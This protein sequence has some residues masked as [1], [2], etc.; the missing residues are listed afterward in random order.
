M[1]LHDKVA[2][3]TGASRGLGRQIALEFGRRGAKVVIAAR[4]VAPRRTLEGTIFQT[5]DMIKAE[6]GHAIAIGCDVGNPDDIRNLVE[7][8]IGEFGRL[9]IVVNNAADMTGHELEPMVEA[10][11]GR[12]DPGTE[13]AAS[14]AKPS[15]R[16]DESALQSWL[17]QFAV[18][19]H[20]PF[21]LTNLARPYMRA[22]GG[23]VIVNISS[24]SADIVAVDGLASLLAAKQAAMNP[25][26]GYA[27]TKAALNRMTNMIATDLAADN[28]AVVAISPGPI[29]TELV[30]LMSAG[31]LL[32][33]TADYSSMS[34]LVEAVITP[35]VAA[36]PMA[37]S[38]QI[39]ASN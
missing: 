37:Y 14:A 17:H 31:G 32:G 13:S 38:G 33:S 6:G 9:D 27:A 11:L 23:G 2:I 3:V 12:S 22:Q 10:M 1:D 21:L 15:I 18:N 4:T 35:I 25:S 20:A 16:P 7:E 39:L 28:I 29:H 26:I 19:V 5:V 24:N 36:D 34:E 30:D 8:T